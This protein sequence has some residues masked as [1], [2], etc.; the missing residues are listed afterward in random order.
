MRAYKRSV[1]VAGL[2]REE[3]VKILRDFKELNK[4]LLTITKVK[5]TDDLQTCRIFYSVI[6]TKEDIDNTSSVLQNNIKQIRF[7]LA[8]AVNL[9]RIP[10][11]EFTYDDSAEK[12]VRVFELLDK[13]EREKKENEEKSQSEE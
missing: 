6:G 9:R 11:I 12:A 7:L 3:I 2:I 4:G 8:Q 10:T 1:R 13:M 5:L